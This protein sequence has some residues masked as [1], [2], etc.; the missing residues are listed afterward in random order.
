LPHA[1]RCPSPVPQSQP[2]RTHDTHDTQHTVDQRVEKET[3]KKGGGGGGEVGGTSVGVVRSPDACEAERRGDLV[4]GVVGEGRRGI[5]GCV[6]P[7]HLLQ[8]HN[9]GVEP[10]QL[11]HHLGQL[12]APRTQGP[13]A[14]TSA[15]ILGIPETRAVGGG[16]CT[17]TQCSTRRCGGCRCGRAAQRPGRGSRTARYGPPGRAGWYSFEYRACGLD[18][19]GGCAGG[20]WRSSAPP[21]TGGTTPASGGCTTPTPPA[22]GQPGAAATP[23]KTEEFNYLIIY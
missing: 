8:E 19:A 16:T 12:V 7:V 9:I 20:W 3:E 10:P 18:E 11:R 21:A 23:S 15:I 2:C 1:P 6:A 4:E 13:R 5:I 14:P 22:R 17:Q